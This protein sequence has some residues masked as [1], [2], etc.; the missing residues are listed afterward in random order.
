[1]SARLET[2]LARLHVDAETRARFFRDPRQEAAAAGLSPTEV[3]A[4][5]KMDRVGLEMAAT[6]LTRKKEKHRP[7]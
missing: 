2:F 4:M 6:S 5:V 7:R 3:E 1:M